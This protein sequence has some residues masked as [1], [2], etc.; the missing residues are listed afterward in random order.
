MT[1][2]KSVQI[3]E[4]IARHYGLNTSAG[5]YKS[6]ASVRKKRALVSPIAATAGVILASGER[7]PEKMRIALEAAGDQTRSSRWPR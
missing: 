7:L 2:F 4:S 3:A 6:A 5:L 1:V